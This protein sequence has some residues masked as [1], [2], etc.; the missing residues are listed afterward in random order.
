M[1]T[2]SQTYA[3]LSISVTETLVADQSC[4]QHEQVCIAAK[5]N[6]NPKG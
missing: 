4:W 2:S 1:T 6:C 3:V 5:K